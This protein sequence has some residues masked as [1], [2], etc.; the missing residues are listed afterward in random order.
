MEDDLPAPRGQKK[1][2]MVKYMMGGG[3]VLGII[4][5][6]WFPLALFAFSNTV[7]E[8]N[9][10]Y[11]VAVSLRIGPYEPVYVMSSQSDD[12]IQ[13]N[14]IDWDNLNRKY[15]KDRSAI[16]FLSN[17]EGIDVAAVKLGSNSSTIWNI[18]PPDRE[19]LLADLKMNKTLTTRF[20]FKVSRESGSKEIS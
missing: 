19:R 5:V 20:T 10:P 12:I 1:G 7:G 18:S 11:D 4:G 8:P 2:L 15:M 6:I 14:S 9:L 16:T 17:Y 13:F 3:M